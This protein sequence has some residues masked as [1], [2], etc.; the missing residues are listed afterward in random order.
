LQETPK[1]LVLLSGI[2]LAAGPV[3]SRVFSHKIVSLAGFG[4][5]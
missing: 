5:R 2:S 4:K 1:V 3:V